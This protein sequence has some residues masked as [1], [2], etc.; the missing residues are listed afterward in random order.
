MAAETVNAEPVV[1]EPVVAEAVVAEP[2]VAES[3]ATA[4]CGKANRDQ[5]G[6]ARYRRA[7][8][9]RDQRV[10]DHRGRARGGRARCCQN[11]RPLLPKP[12]WPSPSGP[13]LLRPNPTWLNHCSQ[14]HQRNQIHCDREPSNTEIIE[15]ELTKSS[16]STICSLTD[17]LA[18]R[19]RAKS[20]YY[21]LCLSTRSASHPICVS[22]SGLMAKSGGQNVG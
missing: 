15:G 17:L 10:K 22:D 20:T 4:N 3:I 2:D 7:N 1:A 6:Q 19:G 8:R 18:S 12:S 21:R 14:I 5:A 16:R 13:S 11:H 9:V